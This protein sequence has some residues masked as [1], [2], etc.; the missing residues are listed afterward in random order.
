MDPHGFGCPGSESVLAIRIRNYS[1]EFLKLV[2]INTCYTSSMMSKPRSE[3]CTEKDKMIIALVPA[4]KHCTD[5]D[6]IINA[7]VPAQEH[8]TEVEK[9]INARVP[10]QKLCTKVD[11]M[12]DARVLAQKHY[13]EVDQLINFVQK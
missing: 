4:Q 3:A 9:M 12:T 13:T 5:V 11:K 6:K 2:K 10:D 7:R 1:H 8:C